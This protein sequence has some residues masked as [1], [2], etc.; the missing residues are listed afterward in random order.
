MIRGVLRILVA[1]SLLVVFACA[2]GVLALH[3]REIPLA[4]RGKLARSYSA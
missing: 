4:G 2:A 1:V 3:R